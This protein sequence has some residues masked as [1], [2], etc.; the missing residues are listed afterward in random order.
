MDGI[1]LIWDFSVIGGE[2]D[3]KHL[4]SISSPAGDSKLK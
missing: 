2:L 3:M 4:L 1:A